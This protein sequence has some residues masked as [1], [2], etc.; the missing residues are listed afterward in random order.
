M[1]NVRDLLRSSLGR[2]LANLTPLDRLAAAWPVAAGRVIAQHSSVIA[3]E[4]NDV[5]V[6]VESGPWLQQ[7]RAMT[8]RL[9]EELQ[10]V[11]GIAVRAIHFQQQP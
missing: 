6:Q 8:P 3:L 10:R 4:D 2:A 5:T 7:L 9:R 11:A 1:E